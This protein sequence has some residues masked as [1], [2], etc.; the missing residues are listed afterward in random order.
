MKIRGI[1]TEVLRTAAGAGRLHKRMS[2]IMT[3]A[4]LIAAGGNTPLGAQSLS[5]FQEGEQVGVCIRT[6]SGKSILEV[7]R[8]QNFIPASN[9]KVL[10]TGLS[11]HRLGADYRFETR[12]SYSGEIDPASGTL[13]GDIYIVGGGDPTLGSG[14]CGSAGEDELCAKWVRSIKQAGIKRVEGFIIGDSRAMPAEVNGSWMYEDLGTYYGATPCALMYRE[15]CLDLFV[16]PGAAVGE[17]VRVEKGKSDKQGTSSFAPVSAPWMRIQNDC[18]TGECH[19]GDRTYLF[20]SEFSPA[21][22]L[23]GTFALGKEG[24]T[25]S[26]NNP[27]PEFS[28]AFSLARALEKEGI[29]CK[30]VT[31]TSPCHPVATSLAATPEDNPTTSGLAVTPAGTHKAS[32]NPPLWAFDF[33]QFTQCASLAPQ[34]SLKVISRTLSPSLSEIVR[35]TNFVS[36]NLYAETLRGL[37][38]SI[39]SE[40]AA[41]E[42][43]GVDTEGIRINDGC[44]LS[45]KNSV[46]PEFIVNFLTEMSHSP[47]FSAFRASLPSGGDHERLLSNAPEDIR[48]RL[49]V[50]SGSMSGVLCY[51]GYILPAEKEDETIVFSIMINDSLR[52]GAKLRSQVESV[53]LQ[54]VLN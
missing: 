49:R 22:C 54:Y 51:C 33:E 5:G 41:L 12:L 34:D 6:L 25:V 31:S 3:T 16:E 2:L 30:A 13:R 1:F 24:K 43:L 42:E 4:L 39:E 20:A 37:L 29:R 27:F 21:G 48:K 38:G 36:H 28:A 15:N 17:K 40:M 10:S 45:R 46:S 53:L 35:R 18:S 19:S 44:G 7:N 52:S 8:R 50:K 11:L 26:Y 32:E 47:A 23:R 14:E 9:L